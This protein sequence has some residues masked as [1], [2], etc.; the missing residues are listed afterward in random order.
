MLYLILDKYNLTVDELIS[1]CLF[2]GNHS[3]TSAYIVIALVGLI[4]NKYKLRKDISMY[5]NLSL[6]CIDLKRSNDTTKIIPNSPSSDKDNIINTTD[7]SDNVSFIRTVFNEYK[8][9]MITLAKNDIRGKILLCIQLRNKLTTKVTQLTASIAIEIVKISS[10]MGLLPLDYYAFIPIDILN[11]DIRSFMTKELNVLGNQKYK[12]IE[13]LS[14]NQIADFWSNE[15]T[16]L[17]TLYTSECTGNLLY[18]A[19][20]ILASSTK[21]KY[22]IYYLPRSQYSTITSSKYIKQLMFRINTKAN[23][24]VLE[25]YNGSTI[26]SCSNII[27]FKNDNE[28]ISKNEVLVQKKTFNKLYT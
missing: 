24:F 6:I 20:S 27:Q 14:D 25:A 22:M 11:N 12:N 3:H 19:C 13:E 18:N 5:R 26:I 10:L 23:T 8:T 16:I 9:H 1:M 4:Q 21:K 28:S 7:I 17:Q 15:L 2:I